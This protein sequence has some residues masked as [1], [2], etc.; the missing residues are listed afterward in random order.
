VDWHEDVVQYGHLVLLFEKQ[1]L[2]LV[3]KILA[4]DD[5]G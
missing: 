5:N 4:M 3:D 2:G 1:W